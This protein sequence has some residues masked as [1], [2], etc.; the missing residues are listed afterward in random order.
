MEYDTNLVAEIKHKLLDAGVEYCFATYVD[1]HG[2]PKAKSVPISYFEKMCKG[3]EL[4]TVGALDGMGLIGP[5]E[6]ECA[7]IPDLNS[8][9][10]LPWDKRYA[11]FS[12]DLSYHDR[13][14][15]ACSRVILKRV[16]EKARQM[17][18][19][20][21]L[22]IE[23][24]FYVLRKQGDRYVPIVETDYQGIT[25]AYDFQQTLESMSFLD[26]MVKYMNLLG[27]QVYSFDQ[28]GG[29]GQYEIDFAYSDVLSMADRFIFLRYMAKAVAQSIG[30][31]ATFMPKPFSYDFR[32]AAHFNMSLADIDTG[33]NLFEPDGD[34]L[35]AEY[36]ASCSR[37]GLN[38]VAG[39]LSHAPALTAV[40]CPTFNSYKGLIPQGDMQDISWAPILQTYGRNNRSAMLRLPMNRYCIENRAPD[41]SCNP[42]L[43]A[44]LS[45]AAGL[46]GIEKDL[47]PGVPLQGNL[48]DLLDTNSTKS[49]VKRLPCT[50]LDALRAFEIDP[51]VNETLGSQFQQIYLTQKMKEWER[52]FYRVTDEER[53]AMLTFI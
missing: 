19:T 26:P 46:E 33:K 36:G 8:L 42:Y 13:P 10:I 17:G 3:S 51:L 1:V 40:T 25:P 12:S 22:G 53:E 23:T 30:A 6:D 29:K 18:Y 9:I 28:E 50:L 45:L 52:G 35:A 34:A 11:W 15:D 32:S 27:W 44:A 47:D 31:I 4:F 21:N 37:L 14:Y 5:H 16:V 7:A 24:E 48:Y 43:A 20:L 38:F 2:V 49:E 39:L 41:I